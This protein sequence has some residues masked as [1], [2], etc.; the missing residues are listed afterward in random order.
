MYF[1]EKI[2]VKEFVSYLNNDY[3]KDKSYALKFKHGEAELKGVLVHLNKIAMKH[4]AWYL[5]LHK[6]SSYHHLSICGKIQSP[7]KFIQD[8]M[9]CHRLRCADSKKLLNAR[10]KILN[11]H[12]PRFKFSPPC[13]NF[14][15]DLSV[16]EFEVVPPPQPVIVMMKS[17]EEVAKPC[18]MKMEEVSVAK[19]DAPSHEEREGYCCLRFSFR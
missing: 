14:M 17:S 19:V 1:Y 15:M 18:E 12:Q 11:T 7:L 13:S 8:E 9:A 4:K 16:I 10:K 5:S 3:A 6:E 2:D